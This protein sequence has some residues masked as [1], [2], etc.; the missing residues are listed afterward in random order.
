MMFDPAQTSQDFRF[1]LLVLA[2]GYSVNLYDSCQFEKEVISNH[3]ELEI[4]FSLT[5]NHFQ[6]SEIEILSSFQIRYLM[7]LQQNNQNLKINLSKSEFD[8]IE[9]DSGSNSIKNNPWFT[10]IIQDGFGFFEINNYDLGSISKVSTDSLVNKE[11][12]KSYQHGHNKSLV[13]VIGES[14]F[15]CKAW[16]IKSMS[17]EIAISTATILAEKIS[18]E[19]EQKI[20][21]EITRN[22]LDK[23]CRKEKR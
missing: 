17:L 9:L 18:D 10:N 1:D 22:I 21:L 19:H 5:E 7:Q 2:D 14:A 4:N 12:Y 11:F 8:N 16:Q 15:N 20:S 23:F 6:N 3:Y 13:C